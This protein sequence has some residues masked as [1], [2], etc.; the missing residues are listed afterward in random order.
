V[1][2]LALPGCRTPAPNRTPPLLP[3]QV[4]RYGNVLKER[5]TVATMAA[6]ALKTSELYWV[7]PAGTAWNESAGNSGIKLF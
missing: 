1:I 5:K 6:S 4:K 2:G 7:K 3:N